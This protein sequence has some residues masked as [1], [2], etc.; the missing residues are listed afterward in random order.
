MGFAGLV[1][2]ALGIL[3]PG[4][5]GAYVVGTSLQGFFNMICAVSCNVLFFEP[6]ADCAGMAASCE[7]L[8]QSV[9]PSVISMFATQ[10]LIRQGPIGLILVQASSCFCAGLVFWLGYASAPPAWTLEEAV[11]KQPPPKLPISS[12]LSRLPW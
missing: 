4:C 3:L 9:M 1:H 10:C 11:A 6:L 5:L 12:S 8:A 7:I 2:L